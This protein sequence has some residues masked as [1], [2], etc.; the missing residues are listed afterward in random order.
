MEFSAKQ[1]ADILEGRVVGSEDVVVNSL[2]KIEEGKP[3]SLTFLANPKYMEYVYKT[4]ASIAIVSEDF[5]ENQSLPK[6]LTLIKV[7]DA[8]Q[9]FA[10]LLDFYN[11]LKN[12]K[13]GRE[14][15]VYIGDEV[16]L[17]EEIYLGAFVYIGKG[18]KIGK[19]VKIYPNTYIGDN[20]TIGDGSVIYAGCKLYTDTVIGEKCIIHAG[21]VLGADGFGFAPNQE[22][23]YNKVA[24]IGNVIIESYVEIGANACVDRATLGSTVV[25]KGT[26]LDNL[27][28]VAHNCDIGEN[29]VI[30]AQTGI[31]GSTKIGDRVM[32][33]G[34]VGII[35]HIE[36]AN[37]VKIAAQSGVGSTIIEEGEILQGSPSMEA[38]KY[39]RAYVGFRKLPE[40]MLKLRE[41]EQEIK[42]LKNE[43]K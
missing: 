43:L 36:I 14:E 38:G 24:Q 19:G 25:R 9:S 13:I 26:K 8:Y 31:A 11:H 7:K 28:Q 30:A 4:E 29:T 1:I 42:S 3:G 34:Q 6:T 12:D 10:R 32:I 39:Q 2:S 21:V 37:D 33:G 23:E 41:L 35:G 27:I 22:N 15:P 18:S 16:E 5:D 40:L 20:V 17:G